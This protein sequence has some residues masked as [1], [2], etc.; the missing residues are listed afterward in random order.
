[1]TRMRA[2]RFQYTRVESVD[3]RATVERVLLDDKT[4]AFL[5]MFYRNRT[6]IDAGSFSTAR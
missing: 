3:A 4:E 5:P 1:M 2:P 6:R